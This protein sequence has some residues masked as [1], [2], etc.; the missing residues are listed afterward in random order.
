MSTAR[1][2]SSAFGSTVLSRILAPQARQ[3]GGIGGAHWIAS[4]DMK[5]RY[6]DTVSV[7]TSGYGA[8]FPWIGRNSTPVLAISCREKAGCSGAIKRVVRIGVRA[9]RIGDGPLA[10]IGVVMTRC[11]TTGQEIETGIE[12]DRRSFATLPFFIAVVSCP[13]CGSEHEFSNK[14]AWLCEALNYPELPETVA[15]TKKPAGTSG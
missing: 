1:K 13:G 9:A 14:D 5:A 12:T 4:E 2:R 11:P 3:V 8:K 10:Y 7:I 15:Q 6:R